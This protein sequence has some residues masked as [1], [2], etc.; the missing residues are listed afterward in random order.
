M[1]P[2]MFCDLKKPLRKDSIK[3]P[4]EN[5][6]RIALHTARALKYLH[7]EVT[8]EKAVRFVWFIC[9]YIC[10]CHSDNKIIHFNL[11]I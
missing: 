11:L 6:V 9:R 5:R 4:W 10:G 8:N 1:Y 2:K 7:S 3:L